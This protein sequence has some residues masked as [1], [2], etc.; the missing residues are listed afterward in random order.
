MNFSNNKRKHKFDAQYPLNCKLKFLQFPFS[1]YNI[2][3]LFPAEN[4]S[5]SC[6]I[7][8]LLFLL[9]F[10]IQKLGAMPSVHVQTAI[11]VE[12]PLGRS[13]FVPI[14]GGAFI[15]LIAGTVASVQRALRS[16][17]FWYV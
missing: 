14:P 12:E 13:V 9:G 7:D 6:E 1:E 15:L 11:R 16:A 5:P 10:N 4:Y 8:V 17:L 2:V 3:I